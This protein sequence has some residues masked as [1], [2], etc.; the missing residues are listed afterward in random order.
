MKS[1][2]FM[3]TSKVLLGLLCALLWAS[4]A[5]AADVSFVAKAN[6]T[7]SSANTLTIA[8]PTGTTTG[9]L[10]IVVGTRN[11][12]SSGDSIVDDNGA[13]PF[14]KVREDHEGSNG[15]QL[16]I[17]RR[18]IQG[19]DPTTWTFD[20]SGDT[21][22]TRFSL[23][24]ATFRD[25]H[26][27]LFDVLPDGTTVTTENNDGGDISCNGVTT[28]VA[29]SLHVLAAGREG[30]DGTGYSGVPAGYTEIQGW[31]AFNQPQTTAYKVI[32]TA[33][34]TGAQVFT[35]TSS[36]AGICQS[37]AIKNNTGGGAT[38]APSLGLMGVGR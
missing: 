37:F 32:A 11:A 15:S 24:S 21:G 18:V 19:G 26:A 20:F 25:Q 28:T 13:T 2:L 34:A 17:F 4:S 5:W 31:G 9:D 16:V 6:N 22:A 23:M 10:M 30:G 27:D 38:T 1:R 8:S 3:S 12:A 36:N 33:S 7:S 35:G 29:G 14:T